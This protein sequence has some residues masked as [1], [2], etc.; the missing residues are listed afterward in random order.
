ME[1]VDMCCW[2][3]PPNHYITLFPKGITTLS[4]VS[5]KEH[6]AMCQ[7]LL[8]LIVDLPL[9]GGQLMSCVLRSV[10]AVLDFVHLAQY[11]SHSTQTLTHLKECLTHFHENKSVVIDLGIC[12]HL[13]I[14]KFHSL[15]HYAQSITLFSTTDNYNTE[16]SECLHIDFTKDAYQATNQ[17]DKYP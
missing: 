8:G 14:P 10:C 16:Q 17:K 6:K 15:L 1:Q 3:L 4:R 9:P 13:N 11:P 12:D 2:A 5:R 7:F